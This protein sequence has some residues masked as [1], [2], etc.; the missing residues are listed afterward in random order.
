VIWIDLNAQSVCTYQ[1]W[2][3]LIL[4]CSTS[5]EDSKDYKFVIFGWTE[6]KIWIYQANRRSDSN[7]KIVSNWAHKIWSF[8]V[9]LDSTLSKDSNDI[10][11][12]IFGPTDQKIWILQDWIKFWFENLFEFCFDPM[13]ATCSIL[14]GWYPFGWITTWS[15]WIKVDLNGPDLMVPFRWLN[16][17]DPLDLDLTARRLSS[18]PRVPV[19]NSGEVAAQVSTFGDAPVGSARRRC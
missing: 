18:S 10:S 9:L 8:T 14:I 13:L 12:V 2:I 6:L 4:W 17:T 15:R 1:I 3:F 5:W 16:R 7:L 19:V 11:F